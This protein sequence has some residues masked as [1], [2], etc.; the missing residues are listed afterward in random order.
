MAK[1]F[2]NYDDLLSLQHSAASSFHKNHYEATKIA[3]LPSKV[4]LNFYH[5]LSMSDLFLTIDNKHI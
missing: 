4:R 2:L 1:W 3:T 5:I